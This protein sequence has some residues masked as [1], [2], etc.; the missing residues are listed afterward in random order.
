MKKIL[1]GLLLTQGLLFGS[2]WIANAADAADAGLRCFMAI[3]VALLNNDPLLI[4]LG[5]CVTSHATIRNSF[6]I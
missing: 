3:H 2:A 1:V 4:C 5:L 6:K